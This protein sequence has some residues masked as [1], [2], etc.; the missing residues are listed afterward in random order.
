ALIIVVVGYCRPDDFG[1]I[2]A[3]YCQAAPA[4]SS[5]SHRTARA[6][7]EQT[8]D[9]V[10]VDAIGDSDRT[11]DPV[12]ITLSSSEF[13]RVSSP[14]SVV[15]LFHVGRQNL[16]ILRREAQEIRAGQV[17]HVVGRLRK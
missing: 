13:A 17:R 7:Q 11:R 15:R 6:A 3:A 1:S 10:E 2:E 9:G 4:E 16:R 12:F 8:A 14:A 5:V